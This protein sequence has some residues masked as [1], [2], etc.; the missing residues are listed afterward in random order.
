MRRTSS[1]VACLAAL[2][3]CLPRGGCITGIVYQQTV[4]PLDV[5]FQ[6]TPAGSR[7]GSASVKDL[8]LQYVRVMWDGNDI[9]RA[10]QK[11]GI[12][13]V[14]YADREVFMILGLWRQDYVRIYGR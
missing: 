10:A 14:L 2:L 12:N 7:E 11:A 13:E 1:R 8:N 6:E 3:V 4:E 9:G 5:N